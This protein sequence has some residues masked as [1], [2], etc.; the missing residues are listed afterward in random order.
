MVNTIL[1]PLSMLPWLLPLTTNAKR[2]FLWTTRNC[3]Q[4]R[5]DPLTGFSPGKEGL[6]RFGG[7]GMAR[8]P[9]EELQRIKSQV[10]VEDLCRDYGIDLQRMGPDNLMGRCPFHDDHTPSVSGRPKPASD[11]RVKTSHFEEEMTGRIGSRAT[12]VPQESVYGE[13]S[14]DGCDRI[15]PFLASARLVA[16]SDRPRIGH[17]PRDRGPSIGSGSE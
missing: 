3:P 1:K 7:P 9:D 5:Q 8:I 2:I 4:T 17:R 13:S 11:G 12:R 10:T 14:Q 16:A 15:N 6:F